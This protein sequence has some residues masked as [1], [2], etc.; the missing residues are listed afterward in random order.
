MKVT[1]NVKLFVNKVAKC[2]KEYFSFTHSKIA[3]GEKDNSGN[4]PVREF[5]PLKV[6][7]N[8]KKAFER[9]KWKH[10]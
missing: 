9:Y 6:H 5:K 2:K 7:Q 3:T 4:W 1:L 8:Y 10:F